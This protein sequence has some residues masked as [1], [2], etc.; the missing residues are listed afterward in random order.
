MSSAHTWKAFDEYTQ[1]K[2]F[3][4]DPVLDSVLQSNAEAGLPSIDVSPNEGKMLHLF[5]KMVGAK[6]MLEI[7][8]LGG[9]SS[10]WLSRALPEDGK[11]VSLE[12]SSKHAAVAEKNIHQAGLSE[13]V[14]ILVGAALDSLPTLPEKGY[15]DFDFIFI[16]ADKR[17]NMRYVQEAIKLSHSG[18]CIV[19]D[20]VVRS[21]Q[22]LDSESDN[23]DIKGIRDMF[24]YLVD[25]PDLDSTA[26]QT[27]GSKGYDGFLLAIVK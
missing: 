2:L 10:I 21:G 22:V 6:R 1:E 11:L 20:N 13:Q 26:I 17:N 25:H 27:V 16:D 15:H 24:D 14:D 12:Y 5:A 19:V 9:Y 18:T 4:A 7:G 8:T 3:T 23:Q